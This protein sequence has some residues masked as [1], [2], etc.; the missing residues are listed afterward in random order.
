MEQPKTFVIALVGISGSGKSTLLKF[1]LEHLLTYDLLRAPVSATTRKK[2][3]TEKD[4]E[5]YHFMWR[6]RFWIN[7]LLGRFLE[8]A[9]IHDNLYGVLKSELEKVLSCGLSPIVD[10]NVD[11]ALSLKKKYGDR[12]ILVWVDGPKDDLAIRERLRRRGMLDGEI[13]RRMLTAR[14]ELSMREL[15]KLRVDNSSDTVLE[16]KSQILDIVLRALRPKRIVA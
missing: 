7:I 5:D 1:L 3:A 13:D 16:A 9:R 2:R 8:Y 15:F 14:R 10:V 11:G 12:A 4:G 6:L